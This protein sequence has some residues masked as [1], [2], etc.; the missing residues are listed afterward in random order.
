MTMYKKNIKKYIFTVI[1]LQR[2]LN[3][4]SPL[5]LLN[6]NNYQYDRKRGLS[7]SRVEI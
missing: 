5:K 6:T 4:F 1:I 3:F 2:I 7:I